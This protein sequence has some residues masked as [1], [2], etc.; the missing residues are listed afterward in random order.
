MDRASESG[1]CSANRLL[2]SGKSGMLVGILRSFEPIGLM[3]SWYT[4]SGSSLGR[5]SFFPFL[6]GQVLSYRKFGSLLQCAVGVGAL[7]IRS[8]FGVFRESANGHDFGSSVKCHILALLLPSGKCLKH[9]GENATESSIRT[10][11]CIIVRGTSVPEI[12]IL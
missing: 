1:S 3:A 12:D 11:N 4:K 8:I 9:K 5:V 6:R 7:V 10:I 2:I